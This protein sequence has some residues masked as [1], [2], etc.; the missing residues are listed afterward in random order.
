MRYRVGGFNNRMLD[1][2]LVSSASSYDD[3][4]T[5]FCDTIFINCHIVK[6]ILSSKHLEIVSVLISS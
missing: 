6:L 3:I 2:K 5:D 1:I 4:F